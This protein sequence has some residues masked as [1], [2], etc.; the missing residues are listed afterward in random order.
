MRSESV[1]RGWVQWQIEDEF[2]DKWVQWPIKGM[3]SVT[4]QG[5]EFSDQSRGWVQ[6]QIEG[7]SSV[8][9]EFSDRSQP[10]SIALIMVCKIYDQYL[11]SMKKCVQSSKITQ[12]DYTGRMREFTPYHAERESDPA[13]SGQQDRQAACSAGQ[14][15]VGLHWVLCS[16]RV[17]QYDVA[18]QVFMIPFGTFNQNPNMSKIWYKQFRKLYFWSEIV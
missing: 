10:S 1:A 14:L 18:T 7:M 15:I 16:V 2:S 17:D 6:W 13:T 9:N 12:N 8:T 5:D 11:K 4:N 3:S